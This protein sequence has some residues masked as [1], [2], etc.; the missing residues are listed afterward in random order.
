MIHENPNCWAEV[1]VII[2]LESAEVGDVIFFNQV[3]DLIFGTETDDP[4]NNKKRKQIIS[5]AIT[6]WTYMGLYMY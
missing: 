2:L 1:R 4:E 6:S 5:E 3:V